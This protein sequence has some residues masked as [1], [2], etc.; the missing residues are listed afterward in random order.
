MAS[1]VKSNATLANGNLAVLSRSFTTNDEG[2]ASYTVRYVCLERFANRWAST[3]RSGNQPPTPMPDYITGSALLTKQPTLFDVQMESYN[4]L[5]YFTAQYS[6]GV[7]T[8]VVETVSSEQRSLSFT[9]VTTREIRPYF[10]GNPIALITREEVAVNASFDY[11][12]YS[13]TRSGTNTEIVARK[14]SVGPVFNCVNCDGRAIAS[15]REANVAFTTVESAT[16]TRRQNG[17]YT[18][19]VTSTGI[20]YDKLGDSNDT[21]KALPE[22]TKPNQSTTPQRFEWKVY[23]NGPPWGSAF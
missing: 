14:G 1:L 17:E 22:P 7:Q 23:P 6:A 4:G 11:I 18:I 12:S 16:R 3:F 2:I 20:Y 15:G 19:S 10:G 21:P 9:Y 5:T 13:V 8:D